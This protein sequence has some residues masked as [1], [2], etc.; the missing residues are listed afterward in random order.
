MARNRSVRIY[1]RVKRVSERGGSGVGK[2]SF[3]VL[4]L[5]IGLGVGEDCIR[6]TLTLLIV[7]NC[8]EDRA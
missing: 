6:I 1:R 3:A 7:T 4:Q 5:G 8:W 2:R